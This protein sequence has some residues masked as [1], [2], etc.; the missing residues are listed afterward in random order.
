MDIDRRT[1]GYVHLEHHRVKLSNIK[2]YLSKGSS[3][4]IVHCTWLKMK[5]ICRRLY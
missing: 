2:I 5:G 1:F 4:K 3:G